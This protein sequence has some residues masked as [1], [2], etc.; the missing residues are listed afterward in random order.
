[1]K[2]FELRLAEHHARN[3]RHLKK[4]RNFVQD[5]VRFSRISP[6]EQEL[7]KLQIANMARL[8]EI[9]MQRMHLHDIPV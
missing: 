7:I 6:D 9:L 2:P 5:P 3:A 4:L 8:D 1:M